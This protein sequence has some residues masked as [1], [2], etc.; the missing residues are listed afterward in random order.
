MTRREPAAGPVNRREPALTWSSVMIGAGGL[1]YAAVLAA[2]AAGA[3][4]VMMLA[5][6]AAITLVTGA[7]AVLA[8]DSWHWRAAARRMVREI[9]EHLA[10]QAAGRRSR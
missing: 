4:A 10:G 6:V 7:V 9:D 8:A 5:A 1:C 2:S 3:R